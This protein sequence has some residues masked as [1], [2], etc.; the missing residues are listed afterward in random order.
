MKAVG[1]NQRFLCGTS[2][3]APKL[4]IN[5]THH[6]KDGCGREGHVLRANKGKLLEW[7]FIAIFHQLPRRIVSVRTLDEHIPRLYISVFITALA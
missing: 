5:H 3:Q 1:F 6:V 4:Q 2:L 7:L